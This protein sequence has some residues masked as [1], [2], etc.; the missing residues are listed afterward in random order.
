MTDYDD[1]VRYLEEIEQAVLDLFGPVSDDLQDTLQDLQRDIA[2]KKYILE[3]P[4]T[5][6]IDTSLDELS[7]LVA[8]TGNA[9]GRISRFVGIAEA[10]Y[11]IAKYRYERKAHS[12]VGVGNN[13]SERRASA[14]QE[15]KIEHLELSIADSV[16]TFASHLQSGA[17][18][19]SETARKIYDKASD[20]WTAQGRETHGGGTW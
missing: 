13:E 7:A 14:M 20:M 2:N 9:Y 8:R 3:M 15:C 4:T 5:G 18:N 1:Q 19:A 11:K 16:R 10:K 6:S 17:Q 12:T